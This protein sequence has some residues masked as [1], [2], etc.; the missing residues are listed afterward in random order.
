M[1]DFFG[2]SA[3]VMALET[4]VRRFGGK[5]QLSLK[6]MW[7]NG[8]IYARVATPATHLHCGMNNL[9]LGQ[10]FVTLQAID[11]IRPCRKGRHDSSCNQDR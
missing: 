4:K 10:V 9:P 8:R 7:D 1:N 5:P 2:K 6:L 11:F 3:L